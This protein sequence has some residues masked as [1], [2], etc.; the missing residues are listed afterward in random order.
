[1]TD[2]KIPKNTAQALK[3]I[4]LMIENPHLPI[5]PMVAFDVCADDDHSYW[6]GSIGEIKKDVYFV[7]DTTIFSSMDNI[8]EHFEM[9]IE[10]KNPNTN[11]S[12]EE[13]NK[14]IGEEI[15]KADI[16]EAIYVYIEMPEIV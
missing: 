8:E 10:I 1:M 7:P 16:K 3:L 6:A 11:F 12:R 2:I 15:K 14:L 5:I 9:E 13:M 4:N